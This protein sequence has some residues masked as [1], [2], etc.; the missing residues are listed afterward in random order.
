MAN[1]IKSH[2]RQ[3]L[4]WRERLKISE[5][6]IHLILAGGV[7]I[8]GGFVNLGF[9]LAKGA[10]ETLI[11]Q[12]SGEL[13][14]VA[15]FLPWWQRLMAPCLGGL[16]AG[17]ILYLGLRTLTHTG[18]SNL[19]EVVVA[20]DGRLP[21]RST[22]V[23][24]LSSLVSICSGGSIGR[25]GLIIRL[26]AAFASKWGQLARWQPYR[27]RLLV[28]CGAASGMA[29]AYNAPIAGAVFAAQIVMGN[30]SMHLFAPLVFSAVVASMVSRSFFG[31]EPWYQAPDFFFTSLRQLPWFILL[32]ILSGF[33]GAGFLK[34]LTAG[35]TLFRK[36]P[37]PLFLRLALGGLITGAIAIFYPEVWG[38]GYEATNH[39]LHSP[40]PLIFII[41][42]L[43]AKTLATLSTV[44]SGA[45]GGVF[46]PTL[47]IGAALGCLFGTL[48]HAV[49]LAPDLPTGVFALV[50]MGS[51]LAATVHSPLLAM[52]MVFE[53]SMNYTFMPP[54][55][56]GC[57]L[58]SLIARN[59]HPA[60]VYT[61]PLRLKGLKIAAERPEPASALER[62]VG[63]L[64]R[65]RV[66][67]VRVNSPFHEITDRFLT[68]S[69]NYLPVVNAGERLV[70]IVALQD[71]KAHLNE[72]ED[73]TL[74]IAYDIMR[75]PPAS[76]T[77]NQRLIDA[78]PVILAS[79]LHNIPVVS[80]TV[81]GRLVGAIVRAEALGVLSE[82][83]AARN[84]Q[85]N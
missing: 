18:P 31:I 85:S 82:A 12:H 45:V 42:L 27:L 75:P 14:A 54:L 62:T 55:M 39:I 56:I 35:N 29:A 57:V 60:S 21:F 78:L 9:H 66:S 49:E 65:E 43:F 46:T 77:P 6:A 59:L 50:G 58:S 61:E 63:D 5:E 84:P 36:L 51:V 17:L 47:F 3:A 38:N 28:G 68:S 19:L 79:D 73:L 32:G 30:F 72:R 44:G 8:I 2:W 53:L 4:P 13:G 23:K 25:E 41:G 81:E 34:L 33:A 74:I 76:L 20:G 71:L 16:L 40:L 15:V 83:I 70:G 37:G 64:M 26:S 22:L 67:P 52:T 10:I 1:F 11:F 7:G 24:G 48:L 80:S 69:N